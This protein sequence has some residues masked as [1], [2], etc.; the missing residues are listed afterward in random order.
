VV[1]EPALLDALE[2]LKSAPWSGRVFR[3]LLGANPPDRPNESGA[4]WNPPGVAALYA[5]LD[6]ST[7]LAEGDHLIAVQSVPLKVTR[8]I[9]ELE[10]TLI[11]VLDLTD[12]AVLKK[13]N[14]EMAQVADN[15]WWPCQRIGGAVAWLKHDGLLVPSARDP[16]GTNLVVLTANME[17]EAEL[18]VRD[19]RL[20]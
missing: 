17:P 10:L 16:D 15:D 4:R 7:A 19:R 3:H 9:Y 18:V 14:I 13:L 2:G 12:L 6:Q 8:T 11:R 1:H 5:S 20:V